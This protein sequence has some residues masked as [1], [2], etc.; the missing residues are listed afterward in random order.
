[1]LPSLNAVYVMDPADWSKIYAQEE[2]EAIARKVNILGPVMSSQEALLR[3]DVLRDAD[4]LLSGWAGPRLDERFLSMMPRLRIVLYGAGAVNYMVTPEFSRR[5]IPIST[6]NHINAIP[7]AEFSFAHIILGLKSFRRNVQET[8]RQRTFILPQVKCAGGFRS[9][10]GLLSLG[11]IG[12]LVRKRLLSMDVNVIA[13]D[14]FVT[15]LE[16]AK[17]DVT[18]VSLDELFAKSDVLSIHAP[19][20]ES[21]R[22]LITGRHIASMKF[23]STLINTARGG[24]IRQDDMIEVLKQRTDISAVLDVV[25]PEPP[26]PDC[27]LFD[28]PNVCLTPHIAGSLDKECSRMGQWVLQELTRFLS[29]KPLQGLVAPEL[30]LIAA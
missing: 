15:E 19:M 20:S 9:T 29:G 24:V 18:M 23:G 12:R 27:E 6:A 14:P 7:V 25:D 3:P 28:L 1:M 11:A 30:L 21:T 17:M 16:A 22:G 4:I 5:N 10:V 2:R 8:L 26:A 13:F